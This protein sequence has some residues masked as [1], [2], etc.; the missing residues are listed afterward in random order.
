MLGVGY[1]VQDLREY[2]IVL[3]KHEIEDKL[4]TTTH[5]C[6]HWNGRSSEGEELHNKT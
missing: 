6:S 2:S 3:V 1:W 5:I 4:P